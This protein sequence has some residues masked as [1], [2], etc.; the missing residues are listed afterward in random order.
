MIAEI[1]RTQKSTIDPGDVAGLRKAIIEGVP[2]SFASG[3][4][5]FKG[6]LEDWSFRP[7]SR[8][9]VR[10]PFIITRPKNLGSQQLAAVQYVPLKDEKFRKIPAM[11]LGLDLIRIF[12]IDDTE[13]SFSAE[14][15]LSMRNENNLDINMIEFSNV[16]LD[17]KSNSRQI[18]IQ[19]LHEGGPSDTYPATMKI[20]VV[21]GKF[22]LDPNYRNHPFDVQRFAIELR[23]KKG[24]APFIVQPL[25]RELRNKEFDTEGW[26]LKDDFVSYDQD[27]VPIVDAKTLE[28]SI[29]PFYK[30]SFVWVL[31]RNANDFYLRVVIPLIFILAVAY[32]AIFIPSAHFE[33]I[34]TIQVTALLSAVALYITT[35]K[36]DAD[37]ATLGDRVFLFNYMVFSVMIGIS[38]LR[39]NRLIASGL[40]LKRALAVLHVVFIPVFVVLMTIYVFGVAGND[41]QADLPP[42]SAF[43]SGLSR[44]LAS[45]F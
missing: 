7:S 6:T 32:L 15:Y 45:L 18:S 34:V 12:R 17:P 24:D 37:T 42:G 22:I 2:A 30:G 28:P 40:H 44:L 25:K 35:P 16:F 14:F 26:D 9:A 43:A 19:A 39:V 5:A 11:Y 21:S 8:T 36:I 23:P 38:I 3:R 13:K 33:A 4:G 27:F 1:L 29:I 41:S 10:T 31:K 20:Y